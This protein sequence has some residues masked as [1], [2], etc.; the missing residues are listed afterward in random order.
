MI[1]IEGF[2]KEWLS[3]NAVADE[4]FTHSTSPYA[5]EEMSAL[6]VPPIGNNA[7]VDDVRCCEAW[8]CENVL[9]KLVV[10]TRQDSLGGKFA[11]G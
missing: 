5:A 7:R 8:D 1:Q 3:P 6:A 9:Q 4:S 2:E 11:T 10:M